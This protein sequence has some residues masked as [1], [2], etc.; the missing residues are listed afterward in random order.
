MLFKQKPYLYLIT[1]CVTGF[2]LYCFNPWQLY[3]QNDDFT[4]VLLSSKHVLFQH[5]AFRPVCD[6]SVMLDYTLWGTNP[7][8][9]HITNLVLHIICTILVF[10]LSRQVFKLFYKNACKPGFAFAAALLFF[11]YPMHSESVFWILGR[12]GTLGAIFS[13]LSLIFLLKE[14]NKLGNNILSLLFYTVALLTYESSWVLPVVAAVLLAAHGNGFVNAL[15]QKRWYFI[16][17]AIIFMGYLFLKWKVTGEIFG[18]YEGDNFATLNV[19]VLARNFAQMIARSFISYVETP[20]LLII[21]FILLAVITVIAWFKYKQFNKKACFIVICFLVALLPCTSLGVDLHGTDG[22]RFLYLPSVFACLFI[23]LMLHTLTHQAALIFACTFCMVFAAQLYIITGNY[24]FAGKVV[25]QTMDEMSRQKD[26][27]DI[28][29]EN[30]PAA[31]YGALLFAAGLPDAIELLQLNKRGINV[32]VT[33]GRSEVLPLTPPYK[34][35]YLQPLDPY[36][37]TQYIYT[38]STLIIYK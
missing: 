14:N 19:P 25:K 17:M 18:K 34:T 6:L 32:Q 4:H 20:L 30:L 27:K 35:V 3:F 37:V 1:A 26:G 11:I 24:R 38:D 13:L 5:N 29:I 15:K 8:G 22:E 9:Y 31:H 28:V 23:T 36:A 7:V 33:S 12:S 10:V 2:A 21:A 16:A